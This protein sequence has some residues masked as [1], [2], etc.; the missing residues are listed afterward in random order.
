MRPV[1]READC[2]WELRG[3]WATL[4]EVVVVW[5]DGR[6]RGYV[7]HVTPTDVFALVWDGRAT[8]HVPLGLLPAVRQPHF[9][10]PLDGNAVS[11]PP[12]WRERMTVP[13]VAGQLAF[14]LSV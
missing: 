2:A 1:R 7:E 8:V 9:D 3:H 5:P 10:E 4:R 6:V 11:P 12:S 13:H 14:R